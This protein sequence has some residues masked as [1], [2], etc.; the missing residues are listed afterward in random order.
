M[1]PE[2][3][4]GEVERLI[5][6]YGIRYLWFQDDDFFQ[7]KARTIK[8]CEMLLERNLRIQWATSARA[9][10]VND[11]VLGLASRA[12]CKRIAFGFE[13]GSQRIIDILDKHTKVE[14][15]LK[16]VAL[17]NKHKIGVFGLFMVGNPTETMEDI[18]ATW[19]FIK[20]IDLDSVAINITTPFPG[21]I[22]W[23]M[24]QEAGYIGRD[25]D[26]GNFYFVYASLQV[27]G[28]FTPREVEHIKRTLLLKIYLRHHKIRKRFILKYL[29]HPL[30]MSEKML[31]YLPFLRRTAT[32]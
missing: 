19:D 22:L 8:I 7:N 29:R 18:R 5:R 25:I 28:T 9:D 21:T 1:S 23:K 27:P 10:S 30:L 26:Y 24:C 16:A 12:G 32:A 4:V 15:N 3:V 31:D 6:D 13:S 20:K 2:V 11:E 14:T 17:C